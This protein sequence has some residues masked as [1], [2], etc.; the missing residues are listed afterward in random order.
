MSTGK[1][2]DFDME[3]FRSSLKAT[4][5]ALTDDDLK[6]CVQAGIKDAFKSRLDDLIRYEFT[7]Q[8]HDR[9]F[10]KREELFTDEQ[11]PAEASEELVKGTIKSIARQFAQEVVNRSLR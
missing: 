9:M 2:F 10:K 3:G 5:E 1:K 7:K 8:I 6:E 11:F 4:F